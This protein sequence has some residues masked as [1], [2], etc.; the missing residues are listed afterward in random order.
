V[1]FDVFEV[2]QQILTGY[3]SYLLPQEFKRTVN[4]LCIYT[5]IANAVREYQDE[6]FAAKFQEYHDIYVEFRTRVVELFTILDKTLQK[7]TMCITD[8]LDDQFNK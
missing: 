1:R 3:K 6:E 8:L 2:L 5:D 7:E 4:E